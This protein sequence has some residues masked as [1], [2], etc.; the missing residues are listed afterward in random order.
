MITL[1]PALLH[2]LTAKGTVSFGGSIRDINPT[3]ENY[4][5]GKLK[6]SGLFTLKSKPFGYCYYGKY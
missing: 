3:N 2:F 1:I 5:N 4:F 6:L